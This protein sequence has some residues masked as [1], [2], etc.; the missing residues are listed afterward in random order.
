MD[1]MKKGLLT[2]VEG[3]PEKDWLTEYLSEL[4]A[5]E[6]IQLSAA[7]MNDAPRT[8]EDA[9]ERVLTAPAYEVLYPA[10]NHAELGRYYLDHEADFPKTLLPYV[11]LS[12]LGQLYEDEAPGVFTGDCYVISPSP[13]S[14]RMNRIS[15]YDTDWSVKLKLASEKCPDGVW[16][17]LPDIYMLDKGAPAGELALALHALGEDK[18]QDCELLEAR[19]VL[20]QIHDLMEQ[21][22]DIEELVRDGNDLGFV[23]EE[24]GQGMPDFMERFSA[25]LDLENCHDLKLALDISQ[26]LRCYDYI[27]ADSLRAYAQKELEKMGVSMLA[28]PLAEACI[29]YSEFGADL[30][31]QQGYQIAADDSGYIR[32]NGHE[33]LYERS[34]ASE[35]RM[36]VS[37]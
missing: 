18:L 20:P 36:H 14:I 13:Q 11:D 31:D 17:R 25:A 33:F 30:L 3:L 23:L 28:A 34:C 9:L 35:N 16:L 19:C 12:A 7:V 1:D 15:P 24:R 4:S 8:G 10:G 26:N 22:D 2:L 32:R 5:K 27:K 6:T 37:L 21:Y 29:D